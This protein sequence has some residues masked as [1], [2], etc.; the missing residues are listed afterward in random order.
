M[1]ALAL[2]IACIGGAF[3]AATMGTYVAAG[4]HRWARDEPLG[5][6]SALAAIGCET[7]A[8]AVTLAAAPFRIR[9]ERPTRWTRGVIVLVPELYCSSASFWYLAHRLRAAGWTVIAARERP[10]AADAEHVVAAITACADA[11]PDGIEVVALGHGMG[12]RLARQWADRAKNRPRVVTL[13]APHGG[14]GRL[15]RLL[16]VDTATT[17]D[18]R[19]AA[20]TTVIYSGFDAWLPSIDG[21]YCPGAFNVEIRG[22]GHFAMLWSPRIVALVLENLAPPHQPAVAPRR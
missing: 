5:I 6:V 2:V 17:E 15:Y 11:V 1:T 4:A 19:T 7:L 21:G 13:G 16:G 8:S 18:A 9:P 22:I 14:G 10:R 20:S 3:F 12:G